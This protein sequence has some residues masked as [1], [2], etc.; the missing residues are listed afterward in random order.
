MRISLAGTVLFGVILIGPGIPAASAQ[1][2]GH[3][4]HG[5]GDMSM[6]SVPVVKTGKVKGKI[7]QVN[8]ESITV[9][10]EKKGQTERTTYMFDGRTKKK[11]DLEAGTEV[12][13]KYREVRGAPVATS[14]E[15][16]KPKNKG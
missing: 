11:G 13:V 14:V 15:A 6:P 12:V 8:P 10:M 16:K 4:G 3:G 9:E 2:G 7:V 1:H 5:G